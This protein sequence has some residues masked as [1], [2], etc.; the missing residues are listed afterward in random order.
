[1]RTLIFK[2]DYNLNLDVLN[3]C[4]QGGI[5]NSRLGLMLK[6]LAKSINADGLN[7]D[8]LDR[9]DLFFIPKN[10]SEKV[11]W[12]NLRQSA[13]IQIKAIDKNRINGQKGGRPKKELPVQTAP[14]KTSG[15]F[16]PPTLEEVL[17]YVRQQNSFAGVGGFSCTDEQATDF[18][19]HYDRQGWLLG[20]GIHMANWHSGVMKWAKEQNKQP[21]RP[22]KPTV[23]NLT[24]RERQDLINKEKTQALLKQL[25]EQ[26]N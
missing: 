6:S 26:G 13:K 24:A 14:K 22:N 12:E 20:N 15:V 25:R 8:E 21:Q 10:E 9:H 18:F 23:L 4:I 19:N 1:M 7:I 17:E 2:K 16:N 3:K 11:L 5:I